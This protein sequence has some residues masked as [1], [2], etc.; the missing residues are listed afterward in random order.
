MAYIKNKVWFIAVALLVLFCACSKSDEEPVVPPV[1]DPDPVEVPD[2]VDYKA[3]KSF[4]AARIQS[5]DYCSAING[6]DEQITL[7]CVSKKSTSIAKDGTPLITV[8]DKGNWIVDGKQTAI[9]AGLPTVGAVIPK[10]TVSDNG[11]LVIN[12]D[13]L[14][15]KAGA[16]LRCVIDARKR[17]YFAFNNETAALGSEIY[18]TYNPV[19]PTEVEH[20]NIL[21]IGNSFTMDAT[22][23]LP[24]LITAA[25]LKN[26]N[27]ARL[28]H[29]GYTL[30]EYVA[31]VSKDK[32]CARRNSTTG[33]IWWDG[34][35]T[36]NSSLQSALDEKAWDIVVIQ[37]HTGRS[38]G[39]VWPGTLKSAVS[40][41]TAMIHKSQPYNRPTIVYL[42]SQT[43]SNGSTVLTKNFGNSR[44]KMYAT[45]TDV[46]KKLLDETFLDIVIPSGTV[47]ENLRTTSLNVDNGLQLT[48]DSYHM[49]LG[50]SCYAAACAVFET[51]ITPC[52]GARIEDNPYRYNKTSSTKGQVCTAVTDA[53]APIAQRAARE[54]VAH[55]FEVTDL[56]AY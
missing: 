22:D 5:C 29:G 55:P 19:L 41:L 28:Y 39:W 37:E 54:A 4:L 40:S 51:I 56:S 32:I 31:N 9:S 2:K 25:G 7:K 10:V 26:I 17:I 11:N 33:S 12:G 13:D 21:F 38:E 44:D 35:N 24:G 47:L 34:D 1:K 3:F 16:I 6:D 46:V 42:M 48:R 23:H 18:G 53:N 8:G 15:V 36:L 14:G 20:L 49:D 27:M 50:I 43:Y 45:T 30:P 52:T